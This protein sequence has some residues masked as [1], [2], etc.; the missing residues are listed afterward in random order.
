MFYFE[1]LLNITPLER[2]N[3]MK[4]HAVRVGG[5]EYNDEAVA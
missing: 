4:R 2:F 5:W 3:A 1:G